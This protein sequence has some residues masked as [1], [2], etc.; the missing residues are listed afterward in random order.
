MCSALG[1]FSVIIYA[2]QIYS[3]ALN[4]WVFCVQL[5]FF[6]ALPRSSRRTDSVNPAAGR[7]VLAT[8]IL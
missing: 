2:E 6:M 3:S 5:A 7:H 1:I 8:R 4:R